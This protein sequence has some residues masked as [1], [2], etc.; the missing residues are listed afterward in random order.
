MGILNIGELISKAVMAAVTGGLS[1]LVQTAIQAIARSIGQAVLQQIGQALGLPRG[2]I[3]QGMSL[4]DKAMGTSGQNKMSPNDAIASFFG[5]S[6]KSSQYETGQ[7][8]RQASRGVDQAVQQILDSIKNDSYNVDD[9]GNNKSRSKGSANVS[10]FLLIAEA[11][12][13]KLN[14]ASETLKAKADAT[15]WEK[16]ESMTEYN[17]L[18]QQFSALMNAVN[19]AIKSI[20]EAMA[21]MAR[22]S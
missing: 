8:Q 2:I 16:G 6:N 12:G 21:S 14:D 5:L 13:K 7:A 1:A 11:L 22:K 4:F 10:W 18:V 15:D 3:D 17:A 20:G 19:S 9:K